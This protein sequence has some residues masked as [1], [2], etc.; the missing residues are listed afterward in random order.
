VL[1][2]LVPID[3]AAQ[4]WRNRYAARISHWVPPRSAPMAR[5]RRTCLHRAVERMAYGA[6]ST[7]AAI[8]VCRGAMN[9]SQIARR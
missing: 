7:L 6:P 1:A 3:R 9:A 8:A 4:R 2:A 5:R